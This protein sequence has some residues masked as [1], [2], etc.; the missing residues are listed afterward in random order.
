MKNFLLLIL[1]GI[2]FGWTGYLLWDGFG[3]PVYGRAQVTFPSRTLSITSSTPL[4]QPTIVA[5]ST[6]DVNNPETWNTFEFKELGFSMKL[7]FERS[8]VTSS[9]NICEGECLE[10]EGFKKLFQW[11]EASAPTIGYDR[12]SYLFKL[13]SRSKDFEYCCHQSPLLSMYD[14][15][16]DGK[17]YRYTSGQ[18]FTIHPIYTTQKQGQLA[19]VFDISEDYYKKF[20]D[21]DLE[22]NKVE[23]EPR[24]AAI[25]KLPSNSQF[26]AFIME[27]EQGD[28]SSISIDNIKKIIESIAFISE[29]STVNASQASYMD[30]NYGFNFLYPQSLDL[31][32]EGKTFLRLGKQRSDN[33]FD[34]TY[35]LTI[36]K[37]TDY[38]FVQEVDRGIEYYDW[39][40]HYQEFTKGLSSGSLKY[41]Q[42]N[43]HNILY[44]ESVYFNPEGPHFGLQYQTYK[45]DLEFTW[46]LPLFPSWYT[47]DEWWVTEN[48]SRIG[49]EIFDEMIPD[50]KMLE[51]IKT[52][53]EMIATFTLS[54]K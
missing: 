37:R 12:H 3:L 6:V 1:A 9:Y 18:Q 10:L 19:V 48:R 31:L 4:A 29:G 26:K 49:V 2:C 24:F 23:Y 22:G 44:T 54:N 27:F 11:V 28:P 42:K 25:V 8:A 30:A 53:K 45:G 32:N 38:P 20:K 7:P 34:T 40:K 35:S 21:L 13:F 16:A 39:E 51:E 52:F 17:N 43:I 41:V 47:E 14:F 46:N 36:R 33:L 5:S 50:K 15:S